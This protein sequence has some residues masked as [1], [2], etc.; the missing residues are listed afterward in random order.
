MP[1]RELLGRIVEEFD[2]DPTKAFEIY[3]G[4]DAEKFGRFLRE[5]IFGLSE[6]DVNADQETGN[7]SH[8]RSLAA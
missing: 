5:E 6:D 3:T 7:K 1:G 4:E 2:L 8:A